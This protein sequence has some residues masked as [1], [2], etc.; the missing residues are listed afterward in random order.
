MSKPKKPRNK[1]HKPMET[2]VPMMVNREIHKTVETLEEN[3]MITAF[4]FGAATQKHYDYLVR[5][6]NMMNIASQLKPSPGAEQLRDLANALSKDILDRYN[7]TG[8]FGVSSAELL[9]M[10]EFVKHYDAYWKGATTTLYNE[11]VFQ[12]NAFYEELEQKRKAA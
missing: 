8:K 5:I 10:R 11:C 6:G 1:K 4:Q 7:K 3:L 2:S 12:L 9:A